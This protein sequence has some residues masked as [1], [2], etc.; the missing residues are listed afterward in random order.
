MLPAMTPAAQ[1]RL[2][3]GP[4]LFLLCCATSP[5]RT[6]DAGRRVCAARRHAVDPRRR[7]ALPGLH[8]HAGAQGHRRRRQR[9][10]LSA[11][12]V[13]R[14]YINVTGQISHI[15]AFRVTPDIVARNRHRQLA[16]RELHLPAEVRVRAVQPR[17][18]DG[19]RDVRPIRHAADAVGRFHRQR[20]PLPI[21][22]PDHGG[23]RGHP[24]L[25]RRRRHVPVPLRPATTAKS[26]AGFYNG[27]NYNRAEANDQKALMVRAT[28]RPLP[29]SFASSAACA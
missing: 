11:F 5:R 13:G 12:N 28:L 4:W 2:L 8:V 20:L 3:V 1:D 16:E 15:V 14:A 24:V 29:G 21:P 27:D 9:V 19:A 25:V 7:D 6:G 26:T 18:L 23:P 10:N 22:G 17:R